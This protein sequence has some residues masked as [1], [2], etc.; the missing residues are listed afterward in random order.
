MQPEN[1]ALQAPVSKA[2][3]MDLESRARV[4]TGLALW[5]LGRLSSG[6]PTLGRQVKTR[7]QLKVCLGHRG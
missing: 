5:E 2:G 6:T 1:T 4:A 7:S 3:E